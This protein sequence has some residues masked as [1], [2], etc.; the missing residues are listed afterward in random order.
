[1]MRA[2]QFVIRAYDEVKKY[3]V[4]ERL[5]ILDHFKL[6]KELD[7]NLFMKLIYHINI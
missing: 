4:K 7:A 2:Q 6:S 1:M 5:V 3:Q